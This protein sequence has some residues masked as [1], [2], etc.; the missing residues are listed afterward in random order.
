MFAFGWGL[1][2]SRGGPKG[3]RARL[4]PVPLLALATWVSEFAFMAL[5]DKAPLTPELIWSILSFSR[6]YGWSE[7][8]ASFFIL[9][10]IIAIARPVLLAIS[11]RWYFMIPAAILCLAST[12]IVISLD[13]PLLATIVGTTTFAS[14]PILPYLPWFLLGIFH[15]ATRRIRAPWTGCWRP[16]PPL[17]S[18]SG[19]ATLVST[20]AA[21]RPLSSGS[22]ARR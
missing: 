20:L 15:A 3:W 1:G 9:Y 11:E 16:S 2:L 21:S 5:V 18:S 4:K 8:L 14:F 13:V 7:F 22:W 6:L 19:H 10:L 17:F 12:W